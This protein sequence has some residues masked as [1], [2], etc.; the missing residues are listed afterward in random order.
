MGDISNFIWFRHLRSE[1]SFH[2]LRYRRGKLVDSGRGLSFW[3]L[4]INTSIAE[5]P[6]GDR[7][8]PF[9]FHGRSRDY[10]DVTVQGTVIY[11]VTQPEVL[12]ERLDFSIDLQRG[13]FLKDPLDQLANVFTGAAQQI[14]VR[15]LADYEVRA[16]LTGGLSAVQER[17][18]AGLR[19]SAALSSLGLEVVSVQVSAVSPTA[20]LEKA[21]QTPTRES[22]QQEA[23]RATFERRALAVEKERAIAENELQNQIELAKREKTLIEQHDENERR[24]AQEE[25]EARTIEANGKAEAMGI[26][27][28]AQA[29]WIETVEGTR[30]ETDKA[31][32]ETYKNVPPA[33]LLGLAAQELAGKLQSIEHLNITPDVLSNGLLGLLE[34]GTAHLKEG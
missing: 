15:Y 16:L 14:A 28:K 17:M 12:G 20:E 25:V 8:L 22:L 29:D 5:I 23:D 10:Q 9:L 11:R 31:R 24:R 2:V 7:E 34:A 4:P 27:A 13:T 18:E 32:W 3:F 6:I 19:D 33:V 26:D 21:L 1:P 30:I